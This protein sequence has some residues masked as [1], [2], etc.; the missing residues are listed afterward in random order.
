MSFSD[1]V[2]SFIAEVEEG[3][4]RIIKGTVIALYGDIIR[5]SPV[6]L[7]R[8]RANWFLSGKNPSTKETEDTDK[9]GQRT[10]NEV[11]NQILS[12]RQ[13]DVFTLT[14]NLPYSEK[15][16]MGSS[17]FAPQ[18]VVRVNVLRFDSLLEEQARKEGYGRI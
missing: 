14:N 4:E 5:F 1:D 12:S 8:F 18:G 11:T 7:G 16:E 9:L 17:K 2:S 10:I 15:I 13:F 3:N 6:K